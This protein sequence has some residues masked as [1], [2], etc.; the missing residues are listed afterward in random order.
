MD[1]GVFPSNYMFGNP[2]ESMMDYDYMDELLLDGCWLQATDGSEF[3]NNNNNNPVFDP[4][5]LWPTLEFNNIDH[6]QDVQVERAKLSTLK[7]LSVSQSQTE[8]GILSKTHVSDSIG[9][10][11][12]SESFLEG[13]QT[14]R[15][16]WISPSAN[17]GVKERLIHAIE[18]I[19]RSSLHK[20]ALIQ[21]WLPENREGKK[22]LS[23]TDQL[24]SLGS[25]CPQLSN[26]RNISESYHFPADGDPKDI[27]GLP[28]RVFMGKVPEWTPDVRF[29]KTEEYP[30]VVHAKQYDVRGSVAVPIFDQDRKSCLGVIEVVM[31]TQKS[32][33]APEIEG[34]CKALEAVDLK[35]SESTNLHKFK[36]TGGLYQ[37]A[38]PEILEIL[39]S[40]CR[41]HNLPLAQT[42]VPCIQQ[43]KDG[44]R[45]SDTNLIHCIS[46]VD[47]ACYVHD[48]RFKDF[49]EACSEHHLLKGQ[50]VVGRAFT[51]NQPCYFSDVTLMTK[52]E[53]PLSHHARVFGLCGVVAIRLRSTFTG[54]V[55]YVL[56]FFLP[57]A[58]KDQEKQTSLLNSLSVIIQ[59]VCRSLRIVTDKELLEEGSVVSGSVEVVKV[60]EITEKPMNLF[61]IQ[62]ND[63]GSGEGSFVNDGIKKPERR[64]GGQKTEKTITLEMLRQYFAGSLKDAAKNLGVCPTTLKRICRQHGIQRWPSRK[65][66]KVGHSLQKIQL[67]MDSVHGAS[68]SFQI[69]SFYSNF[70]ALASPDPKTSS[71]SP[72]RFNTIESKATEGVTKS[73]SPSSSQTSSSG[74]SS[75]SG[76]HPY[77]HPRT[78]TG[79]DTCNNVLKRARSDAELHVSL[80]SEYQEPEPKVFHK[81][82]SHKLLTELPTVPTLTPKDGNARDEHILRIKVTYGEEKIRFR[83]QKDWGFSQLLQEIAKRFSIN[84]IQ[85]FHLKYFDD[86]SEWVLLTC[87]ADLEECIDV[88]RSC[89]SGTIK[90]ALVEPQ[91]LGGSLGSNVVL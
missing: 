50:G 6:I 4:S 61:G 58:C 80:Y 26:Y 42:W 73:L 47:L 72:S 71:L 81:S 8:D 64:R 62:Q 68:G 23:T 86:D 40:A 5:F 85:E 57:L 36:V 84:H 48:S 65:I 19:K 83:L 9:F 13:S 29:F 51:T 41:T 59:N 27:I 21:I 11:N 38:L 46:T 89:K 76:N 28:G 77:P 79:E 49:Q 25:D 75:S 69:E 60:E 17:F 87:D 10:H 88:Y 90:L 33:Y 32:N 24:F 63:T 15:R 66:K 78:P 91:Y 54:N 12:Q 16:W 53:Y 34:V 18:N 39:K 1:D 20:N 67:V 35:S 74:Q 45:H 70:P 14:S 7:N 55:D 56:E 37:A 30:R 43:G 52:T 2:A 31:T 22:V 44:C 82:H 3:I